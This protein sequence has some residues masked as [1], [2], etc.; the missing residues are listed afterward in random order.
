MSSAVP[1]KNR[2]IRVLLIE[3]SEDDAILIVRELESSGLDV[4][5]LQ[6]DTEQAMRDALEEDWDVILSDYNMPK[7]SAAAALDTL[8]K[9]EKDLPFIVVSG[10]IGEEIAVKI[11][12]AGAHDYV[13]KNNLA[14]LAS[15]IDREIDDAKV[16]RQK[17][18]AIIALKNSVK[19]WDVTFDA[20]ADSVFILN[21]QYKIIK[22]NS[23]TESLTGEKKENIIGEK[24][25]L[26]MHGTSSPIE[27]C[28][29]EK[30][31]ESKHRE[32]VI[33]SYGNKIIEITVDPIFNQNRQI[34]GSVHII[35]DITKRKQNEEKL[36]VALVAAESAN[37]A[38]SEFLATI[39]HEI[40][41]PLNGLI[42]FSG[43][44]EDILYQSIDYDQHDK[45]IEYLGIVKTC[46]QNITEL[47][48]DILELASITAGDINTLL[49][50]FSPE[51]LIMESNEILKF[52]AEEKNIALEFQHKNLP[53]E[54][55]G[56][57]RQLKQIIFNLLGNAIKFTDKGS[58]NIN[59]DY[60][61]GNLLLEVKD[62]GIGI[63]D[64]M[65]NKILEPFTQVDQSSTRKYGG[66]GLGLTIVSRILEELGSSLNIESELGIG[67][68][69]SFTFPV[70]VISN[71]AAESKQGKK[72]TF[73]K[74]VLNILIIEDD[75]ISI[76]YL[77][78]VLRNF[79]TNC[80]IA[81]SFAHMQKICNQGF[82][83]DIA[84]IDITLPGA[85]G[86]ECMKWLK[87]KFPEKNIKCIA[88]TAY[89]LPEDAMHY[90]DAGFDGFIA[91]P[92]TKDDIIKIIASVS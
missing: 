7:F 45:V 21:S 82:V 36:K 50:D 75:E 19:E 4:S 14:R 92:Y 61:D 27:K 39:S 68:K 44:I 8:K 80:K 3:D 64:N 16:R 58:V 43:I 34:T 23:A 20:I 84:L 46:G 69:V 12:Q 62:T 32:T 71:N 85:D 90:Q 52:K 88:Q 25:Y 33:F 60:T 72:T 89:V 26:I 86:F 9:S 13:M 77:K 57:K 29:H 51:K 74:T 37:I 11:M 17:K 24:C 22:C 73:I 65:K 40:R 10:A 48:N 47:I 1:Q 70:K 35:S 55:I 15:A 2:K 18:A 76:L 41:T 38:K 6:V 67:T 42:G 28:P 31:L 59:A 91:K 5:F 30:M 49:E 63:P 87:D 53:L 81:K 78:E 54:A 56:A 83:P 79:G 66:T